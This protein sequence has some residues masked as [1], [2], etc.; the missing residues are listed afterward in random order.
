MTSVVAA[1]YDQLGYT[2]ICCGAA[3]ASASARRFSAHR[4]SLG[5]L[6]SLMITTSGGVVVPH[7]GH[8]LSQLFMGLKLR[9]NFVYDAIKTRTHNL[10][11]KQPIGALF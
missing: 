8:H 11:Y 2:S 3:S 7:S 9:R 4:L 6:L 10:W 5:P 1:A